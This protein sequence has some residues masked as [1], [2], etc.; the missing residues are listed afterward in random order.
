MAASWP[1]SE[2]RLGETDAEDAA[3]EPAF[4]CVRWRCVFLIGH[5]CR[6]EVVR[7]EVLSRGS[8]TGGWGGARIEQR[9]RGGESSLGPQ[10]ALAGLEPED[11]RVE[12]VERRRGEHFVEQIVN[13]LLEGAILQRKPSEGISNVMGGTPTRSEAV[14]PPCEPGSETEA[15]GRIC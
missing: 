9:Q 6:Q 10:T 8:V 4:R 14:H 2:K 13:A 11:R 12:R 7:R 15:G 3:G 5:L 1:Q